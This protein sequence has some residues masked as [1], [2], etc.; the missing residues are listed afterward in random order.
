MKL[1]L[2]ANNLPK[3]ILIEGIKVL[4]AGDPI[5]NFFNESCNC[6]LS[7]NP[8]KIY[9]LK[10]N[11]FFSIAHTGGVLIIENSQVR[12]CSGQI[13]QILSETCNEKYKMFLE[14]RMNKINNKTWMDKNA[15]QFDIL[16]PNR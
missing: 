15:E 9:F 3:Q 2:K 10:D 1:N 4:F 14:T 7:L 12:L 6:A 8:G 13:S 16:N 5:K 11:K